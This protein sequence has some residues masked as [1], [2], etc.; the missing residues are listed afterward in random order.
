MVGRQLHDKR[1]RAAGE[2]LGLL[3][4]QARADDGKDAQ[5]VEERRDPS[6][7]IGG[8]ADDGAHEQGDDRQLSA[9][10]D[11]R[12]GHDRHAAVL[13]VLDGLGGHDAGDAAARGHEHGDEGL[14]GQTEAAEHAVHDESD[15]S[16]IAA[17]LQEGQHHKEQ[18][19]LRHEAED[20]AQAS[21]DAVTD[22]RIDQTAVLGA[23]RHEGI[24]HHGGNA[25]DIGAILRR[26]DRIG[27]VARSL[28][29]LVVGVAALTEHVPAIGTE[30]LVVGEVGHRAAQGGDGDVVHGKHDDHEDRQAQDTV[31]NHAVDLLGGAHLGG[32]L[33]H[34]LVDDVGDDAVALTGDDGLGIV[35]A[36]LLA[37][38][39]QLLHASGLLLG[40]VDELAG[41][42]IALEQLDGVVAALVGGDARRQ[43]VL[44][45]G[46]NVLDGRVELVLRHLALGSSGLLNL[47]EQLRDALVLKSRD[48]HDR[49]AELL[50][51]LVGVDL[52]AVLL[53]QVGHVEG[54]DHGQTGLDNL[55]RQV[56]VALEVGGVDHLDDDIGLAA[57][58]VIARALL[59]GAV[60]GK[61]V[62]AGEVRNRDALVTQ[63]LGLL[64][65]NRDTGPVANIAVGAGDQ[66]EKRG[67]AAVGVT[68]QRDMDLR[69]RHSI[70]LPCV[71]ALLSPHGLDNVLQRCCTKLEKPN[72]ICRNIHRR[73]L[74]DLDDGGLLLAD[75][76][77]VAAHVDLDRI[78]ERCDL[79][80][81]KRRALDEPQVHK[82]AA[83]RTLTVKLD[84]GRALAHLNVTQ[85]LHLLVPLSV[86]A[87]IPSS[88]RRS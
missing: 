68:R 83:K 11:E 67:L 6:S 66:V 73:P 82:V 75:G 21:D 51:E 23:A 49:A 55:K 19:H 57:H 3:E 18:E 27:V 1:G 87:K 86:L 44:D 56:Q 14:T 85:R 47:I 34:A 8:M 42:R 46:Q 43:V 61:R 2:E 9:T 84:D 76:K 35:V 48:H 30:E 37:L 7:G 81:L 58:E 50:G 24:V 26:V 20:G 13:L 32:S 45:V 15:A 80:D 60:G 36:I 22:E 33:G 78:S 52:V 77:L 25:G 59:L 63:E 72:F 74:L 16:H 62:D 17:V 79:H 12:G 38:G 53:D 31:G 5:E 69:I 65:L 54:D 88:N 71:P 41:V 70:L 10:G 28:D 64:F 4:H 39:D 40:E 29:G